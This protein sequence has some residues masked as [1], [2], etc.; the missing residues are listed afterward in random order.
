MYWIYLIIFVVAVLSPDIITKDFYF[1][2][3]KRA[4]ELLVFLLG[5][6]GFVFFMWQEHQIFNQ[7]KERRKD[8]KKINQAVKDLVESYSYIGEVNR[9]MDILMNISLG[10]TEKSNLSK[11]KQ[12]EIYDTI[13]DAAKFLMRAECAFIRFINTENKVLEKEVKTKSC[14]CS[15]KNDDIIGVGDNVSSGKIEKFLVVSSQNKINNI[16]CFLIVNDYEEQEEKT[17]ALLMVMA[18]QALFAYSYAG[19]SIDR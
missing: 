13:I 11:S 6:S 8:N 19:R 10:L 1:L 17:V 15:I 5:I 2:P 9:K 12:T 3:E 18:S 16:R 14:D 4:E 7:K